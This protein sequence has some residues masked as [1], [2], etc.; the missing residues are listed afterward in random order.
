MALDRIQ[1]GLDSIGSSLACVSFIRL[2]QLSMAWIGLDWDWI[3]LNSVE[4][5]WI[6]LA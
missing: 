5:D 4:L 2:P 6:G 3:E 1:I